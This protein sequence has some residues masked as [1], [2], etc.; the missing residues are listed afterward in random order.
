MKE[1]GETMK[2]S[3]KK[4]LASTLALAMVAT[5]I[6]TFQKADVKAQDE[7]V[8]F[9]L[10][11][12]VTTSTNEGADLKGE[13]AVD[14]DMNTRWSSQFINN[15]WIKLDF[16]KTV[17]IGSIQLFWEAAYASQYTIEWSNDDQEW[18]QAVTW[19]CSNYM[20]ET[21][22]MFY[23]RPVRY[24]RI[25][26]TKRGTAYGVSLFEIKALGYEE[27]EPT[28][29]AP[30]T[31]EPTTVAPTTAEPEYET[32]MVD[33][34]FMD[35]SDDATVTASSVEGPEYAASNVLDKDKNT[36]W[37]SAFRDGEYITFDFGEVCRIASVTIDWEAAYA[38]EYS[39]DVSVDGEN[40]TNIT[41]SGS[42]VNMQSMHKYYNMPSARYLKITGVRRAT[43]Y[44]I[45]MYDVRVI[46]S[47]KVPLNVGYKQTTQATTEATTVAP[48]TTEA[49]TVAPT[50]E[51][52]TTQ[53]LAKPLEVIG[54]V[55]TE[56]KDN[57][58]GIVWGQDAER[59][60]SGCTYNVYIDG[61]LRFVNVPC[62][63]YEYD[64]VSA[65]EHK[66]VIASVLNHMESAGQTLTIDIK[67]GKMKT[68]LAVGATVTGP[69][70][71]GYD[72]SNLCDG[73]NDTIWRVQQLYPS[74]KIDLG[75]V[76]KISAIQLMWSS[77]SEAPKGVSIFAS[78]DGENTVKGTNVDIPYMTYSSDSTYVP[79]EVEAR[80]VTV[81]MGGYNNLAHFYSCRQIS[82]Y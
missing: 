49:T 16:G 48:T 33:S 17:K 77:S 76:K 62:N 66:V 63:Y 37:S 81:C 64:G 30:T 7:I 60:N 52:P 59:I 70:M 56:P 55:V 44:G 82:I 57:T 51:V 43:P 73:I 54:A 67:G 2:M 68:D 46:G 26:C 22:H 25:T 65:G 50:T 29:V 27:A 32:I 24:I 80:Y 10:N 41:T 79:F 53:E 72:A 28:T 5:S 75:S 61:I 14:G 38:Q 36:R 47:K 35:I 4:L 78:V 18:H 6:V 45:S 31:E 69:S 9:A 15:Q 3:I 74:V 12:T 21:S 71:A 11:A 39:F 8:N 20:E 58:I 23:N 13:K 19:N 42:I 1:E 40:W 34:S